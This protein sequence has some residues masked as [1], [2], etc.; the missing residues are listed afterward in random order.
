MTYEL[1]KQLRNAGFPL[2]KLATPAV[3]ND[4]SKDHCIWCGFPFLEIDGEYFLQPVLD[5]LIEACHPRAADEF[6]LYTK[7]CGA[8]W[9]ASLEYHGFYDGWPACK[10]DGDEIDIELEVSGSTPEE[11]VASLWLELNKLKE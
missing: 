8:E 2:L 1:A 11:A 3:G 5:V 4:G 9:R 10:K 7:Y 6:M